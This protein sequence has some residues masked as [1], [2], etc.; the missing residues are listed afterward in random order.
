MKQQLLE[1][2][3]LSMKEQEIFLEKTLNNWKENYDQVDDILVL[4]IK[5]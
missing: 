1:I 2:Q 3:A 5:I 4:G